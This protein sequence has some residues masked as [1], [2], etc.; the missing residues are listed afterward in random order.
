[1]DR[2]P[3]LDFVAEIEPLAISIISV[4][5]LPEKAK[6]DATHLAF[7]IVHHIDYLLTWNCTHLANPSLQKNLFEFCS[8]NGLHMPV[9]CTPEYLTPPKQ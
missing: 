3:E 2:I 5:T 7:A 4:L 8:Y 6:L 1:M 9:I